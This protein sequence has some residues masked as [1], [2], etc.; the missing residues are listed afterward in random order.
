M[1]GQLRSL[2][3]IAAGPRSPTPGAPYTFVTTKTF[4]S[5]FGF[6]CLRDL[7]DIERLEDA[8]LLSKDRLLADGFPDDTL[9]ARETSVDGDEEAVESDES[10]ADLIADHARDGGRRAR[11]EDADGCQG[12]EAVAASCKPADDRRRM[13]PTALAPRARSSPRT[14]P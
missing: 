12:T 4:L 14:R 2:G 1:I 9:G 11:S 5:H 8:G 7:P 6:E 13:L 3:F 10:L